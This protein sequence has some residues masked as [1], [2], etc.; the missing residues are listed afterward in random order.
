MKGRPGKQ[1]QE[2]VSDGNVAIPEALAF[3]GVGR[4]TLFELM[5]RG[6]LPRVSI[7]TRV[8]IPRR[9]LIEFSARHL[10]TAR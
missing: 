7:G 3:L 5:R 10:E 1:A 8:L 9:A 6:E 2:L 4:S